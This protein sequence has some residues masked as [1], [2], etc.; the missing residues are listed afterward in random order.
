MDGKVGDFVLV[1]IMG[2]GSGGGVGYFVFGEGY[3]NC[4]GSI[5]VLGNGG[6]ECFLFGIDY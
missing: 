4:F 2:L 6:V 1:G 5:M 3:W